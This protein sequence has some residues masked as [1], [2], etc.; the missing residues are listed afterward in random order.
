MGAAHWGHAIPPCGARA[1][2]PMGER[3]GECH[4]FVELA[5]DDGAAADW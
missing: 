2:I 5:V 3:I 4:D 1:A